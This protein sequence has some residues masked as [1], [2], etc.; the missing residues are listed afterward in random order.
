MSEHPSPLELERF[1]RGELGS[2]ELRS[3]VAHFL[4]RCESCAAEAGPLAHIVL[5]PERM[6]PAVSPAAEEAYDHAIERAFAMVRL[7]GVRARMIQREAARVRRA[8]A[9]DGLRG[10]NRLRVSPVAVLEGA[11]A[12]ARELRLSNPGEMV[13][14]LEV[15]VLNAHAL[16]G[17]GYSAEQVHDLQARALAEHANG[18]RIVHDCAGAE[19]LLALA[20]EHAME[21]TGD[22]CLMAR[23]FDLLG[24]LFGA[25]Y[26]YEAAAH[27]LQKARELYEAA[28]DRHLTGRAL[29]SIG[30]YTGLNGD[31]EEALPLLEQG[32]RL[33][34]P[35]RE[36]DLV[37]VAI[38]NRVFFLTECGRFQEGLALLLE[39]RPALEQLDRPKLL[40]IEARLLVGLGHTDAAEAVLQETKT[41]LLER[42]DLA[43]M[44]LACLD[45]AALLLRQ[46]R[47]A[48]GRAE[49]EQ[50]LRIYQDL[51][52]DTEA[53]RALTLLEEALRAE[54]VTATFVQGVVEFLRRRE[55]QP[56]TRFVPAFE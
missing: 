3:V 34:D 15:A 6:P 12:R 37:A 30:F 22:P 26:R 47:T 38:H 28:G 45:L 11:I 19:R 55:R 42:E 21:G 44:A 18:L 16:D 51:E 1:L 2:A 36:P 35:L 20:F 56:W 29:I 4:Q 54:L 13:Q 48:E 49:A 10:L 43:H 23:L 9:H 46:G 40:G 24:S 53:R 14:L 25:R 32:A 7:H 52:L 8:L 50:A 27:V 5:D 33:V 39:H 41:R 31:F 17:A